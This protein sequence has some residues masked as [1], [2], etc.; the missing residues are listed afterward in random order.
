MYSEMLM[1]EILLS[2]PISIRR[3]KCS[4]GAE[5]VVFGHNMSRQYL[6]SR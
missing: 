4:V 1:F 5:S 3:I 2:G 6:Y